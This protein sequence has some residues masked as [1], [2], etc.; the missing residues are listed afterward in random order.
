MPYRFTETDEGVVKSYCQVFWNEE[1]G[2]WSL[3]NSFQQN[4]SSSE[5]LSKELRDFD[6]EISG[7]ICQTPELIKQK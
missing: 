2:A 4:K 6:Y 3:D 5:L 1:V 7:N